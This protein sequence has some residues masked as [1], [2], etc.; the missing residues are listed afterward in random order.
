MR[1]YSVFLRK[2]GIA[3]DKDL[4]LVKEGF[5]WPAFLFTFLWALW[6]RMWWPAVGLFAVVVLVSLA[7]SHLVVPEAY[8]SLISLSLVIAIGFVGNDIRRWWLEQREFTEV[9]VVS[10]RNSEEA[11]RRFLDD[12]D[13]S[14]DGIYP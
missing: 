6:L 10:G 8:E 4:V 5:S 9:A 3:P 12:V 13:V 2:H 7:A 14:P 11:M 1:L